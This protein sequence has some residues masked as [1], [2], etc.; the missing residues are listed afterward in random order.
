MHFT[1]TQVPN[2][3]CENVFILC[4]LYLIMNCVYCSLVKCKS[5]EGKLDLT[6]DG[7]YLTE[8]QSD[9]MGL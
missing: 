6:S 9:P 2:I 1:S 4:I 3:G 5:K 8:S 7:S